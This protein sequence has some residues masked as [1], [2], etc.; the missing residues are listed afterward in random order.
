MKIVVLVTMSSARRNTATKSNK[1]N[2]AYDSMTGIIKHNVLCRPFQKMDALF[3]VNVAEISCVQD[4]RKIWFEMY[5]PHT[6]Q[7]SS[8]R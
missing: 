3:Y 2:A 1:D 5:A 6:V 7:R 8:Q 4:R